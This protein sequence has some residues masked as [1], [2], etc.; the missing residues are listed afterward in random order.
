MFL[1]SPIADY[2]SACASDSPTPGGGSVS[3]LAAALGIT[4]GEMAANFTVGREKFREMEP[5]VRAILEVLRSEGKKVAR[6]VEE[7]SL[8]Y[9]E[10]S[11]AYKLPRI[12][13][14]EKA[15]RTKKIQQ[16]LV[17]AMAVPLDIVRSCL[18]V[19]K[20]LPRLAELANPNLISDVGVSAVLV[21]AALRG[22]KLNVEINLA[23][24]KDREL[25]TNTRAQVEDD[26]QEASKLAAEVMVKVESSIKRP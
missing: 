24:L 19:L 3:A 11:A 20:G 6:L 4:M 21:E 9:Q 12:T 14:E 16:A 25:V 23:Y 1:D 5:E 2:L 17:S 10:L 7:D 8:A 13:G 18:V 22:A 15:A 26:A